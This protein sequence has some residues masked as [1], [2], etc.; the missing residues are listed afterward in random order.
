[1]MRLNYQAAERP[2]LLRGRALADRAQD[3]RQR[4]HVDG[5]HPRVDGAQ[6]GRGQ[7]AAAQE[8]VLRV[9]P[10]DRPCQR[11]GADR[12]AGHFADAGPLDRGR[13]QS[14]RLRHAVLHLGAAADRGREA[15]GSV[16]AAD[17]RAGHRRRDHRSGARRPLFRRGRRGGEHRRPDQAQRPFRD[18]GAARARS[19]GAQGRRSAALPRPT[20]QQISEYKKNP[21]KDEEAAKTDRPAKAKRSDKKEAAGGADDDKPAK[22]RKSKTRG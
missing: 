3:H 2:S 16:P 9:L 11:P 15:D 6:P 7:G 4:R 12:R 22:K 20:E 18:A 5:S 8:Q 14:A 17:D 19:A 1:M 13:P 21:P 10:R